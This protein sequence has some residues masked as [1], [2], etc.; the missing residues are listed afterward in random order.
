MPYKNLEVLAVTEV[1]SVYLL[2]SISYIFNLEEETLST[3][4][5]T[6]LPAWVMLPEAV[7]FPSSIYNRR[8]GYLNPE[9]IS[10]NSQ[11]C[12]MVSLFR[13]AVNTNNQTAPVH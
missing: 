5:G 2:R 11:T 13:I 12:M 4:Y 6:S 9:L 7:A 10:K 8:F 1:M 3:V